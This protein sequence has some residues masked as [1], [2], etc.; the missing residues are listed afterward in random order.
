VVSPSPPPHAAGQ[1][2]GLAALLAAVAGSEAAAALC[3][4]VDSGP[5]LCHARCPA[6][7][8]GECRALLLLHAPVAL[9]E[10]VHEVELVVIAAS[11]ADHVAMS[12]ISEACGFYAPAGP[13]PH[14]R[15][16]RAAARGDARAREGGGDAHDRRAAQPAVRRLDGVVRQDVIRWQMRRGLDPQGV[17]RQGVHEGVHEGEPRAADQAER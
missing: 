10:C 11:C 15:G 12:E 16:A 6:V 13:D 2:L 9:P 17:L 5:Q 14:R 4:C 7:D 3:W 8:C 1:M